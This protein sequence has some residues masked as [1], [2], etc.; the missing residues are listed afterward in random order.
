MSRTTNPQLE[1]PFMSET[2]T[3]APALST[4]ATHILNNILTMD[5]AETALTRAEI[6]SKFQETEPEIQPGT[7]KT[8]LNQLKS[9]GH[10]L[11]DR[12]RSGKKGKPPAIF[13]RK[14]EEM[15]A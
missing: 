4:E 11:E 10:I 13:F 3:P 12:R 9:G 14:G 7:V 15:S 1:F 8:A 5:S 6:L 2:L